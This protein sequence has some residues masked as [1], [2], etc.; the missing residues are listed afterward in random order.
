MLK[1]LLLT[2]IFTF[3]HFHFML[4]A[5]ISDA[6]VACRVAEPAAKKSWLERRVTE[7]VYTEISCDLSGGIPNRFCSEEVFCFCF[8][9]EK[10]KIKKVEEEKS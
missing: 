5:A 4:T 9:L 3:L 2:E 8:T 1:K 6:I 7:K 10:G